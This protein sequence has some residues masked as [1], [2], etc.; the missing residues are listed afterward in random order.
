M[1]GDSGSS[2]IAQPLRYGRRGRTNWPDADHLRHRAGGHRRAVFARRQAIVVADW[3]FAR[4]LRLG[5][6][7]GARLFPADDLALA[8]LAAA[9]HLLAGSQ[10]QSV[11]RAVAS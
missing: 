7:L 1:E 4:R 10:I 9:S 2:L 11:P 5:A 6:R 3:A 8:E